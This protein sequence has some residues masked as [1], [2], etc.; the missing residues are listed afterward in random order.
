MQTRLVLDK[1]Q[2]ERAIKLGIKNLKKKYTLDEMVKGDVIFC[3]T[4]ITN[5]DFVEGII[6]K[7]DAFQAST[8]ALHKSTNTVKKT[9][10][11][12]LK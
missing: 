7:G 6:D 5:G 1:E 2:S 4:E 10:N 8:F 3:A 12:H 9:K 11:T